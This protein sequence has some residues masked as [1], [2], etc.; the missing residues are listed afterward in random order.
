VI[1]WSWT[2]EKIWKQREGNTGYENLLMRSRYISIA[3]I[4]W[5]GCDTQEIKGM[6]SIA[7]RN[8]SG[9]GLILKRLAR[10]MLMLFAR[11][12][13]LHDLSL[14]RSQAG[15]LCSLRLPSFLVLPKYAR[16][17]HHHNLLSNCCSKVPIRSSA[18]FRKP[19]WLN[20][21][22]YFPSDEILAPA[23]S[24]A[25]ITQPSK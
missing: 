5:I 19:H 15:L 24:F 13:F 9:C 23:R 21:S 22:P 7:M 20:V 1:P 11:S 18:D 2:F 12:D 17:K 4:N 8:G 14:V 10:R 25:S 6:P 3:E 16:E